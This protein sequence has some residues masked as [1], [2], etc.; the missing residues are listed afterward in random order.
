MK[1]KEDEDDDGDDEKADE[2]GEEEE[3]EAG[4]QQVCVCEFSCANTCQQQ[5]RGRHYTETSNAHTVPTMFCF[6]TFG[7]LETV[8]QKSW[9]PSTS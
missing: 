3:V 4:S 2:G 5:R 1:E 6:P 8:P 9:L 7:P